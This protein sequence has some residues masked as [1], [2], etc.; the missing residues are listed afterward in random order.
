MAAT[1]TMPDAVLDVVYPMF[2]ALLSMLVTV[3]GTIQALETFTQ[4]FESTLAY[5]PNVVLTLDSTIR[6]AETLSATTT[7]EIT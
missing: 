4:A 1:A 6:V 2:T 7:M 3:N 5:A